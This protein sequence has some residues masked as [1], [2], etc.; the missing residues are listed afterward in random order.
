MPP[1]TIV[2]YAPTT[3]IFFTMRPLPN[4]TS[5]PA[6]GASGAEGVA[7]LA[8]VSSASRSLG[9]SSTAMAFGTGTDG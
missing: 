9:A 4:T 7:F 2:A 1:R 3:G 5:T 8:N 6:P